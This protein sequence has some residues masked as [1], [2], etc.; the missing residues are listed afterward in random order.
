MVTFVTRAPSGSPA[1]AQARV[2][3]VIR[4]AVILVTVSS[5]QSSDRMSFL[6]E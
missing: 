2:G 3:V 5:A 4:T 6:Q 1:L